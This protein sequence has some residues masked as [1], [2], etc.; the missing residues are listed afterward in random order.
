MPVVARLP[1]RQPRIVDPTFVAEHASLFPH[2]ALRELVVDLVGARNEFARD[3]DPRSVVELKPFD[4]GIVGEPLGHRAPAQP[5]SRVPNQGRRLVI[6]S[7]SIAR[8]CL[9][10]AAAIGARN[11][12]SCAATA[13]AAAV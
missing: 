3:V 5:V 4:D 2:D 13:V 8:S 11:S 7:M 1:R 10:S 9:R 6:T 12:R